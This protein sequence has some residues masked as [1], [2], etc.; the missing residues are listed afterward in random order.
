MMLMY[1]TMMLFNSG[2][3]F[4]WKSIIIL[5]ASLSSILY[6][7]L[8]SKHFPLTFNIKWNL[9]QYDEFEAD[10]WEIFQDWITLEAS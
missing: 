5:M 1:V 10:Y 3:K 7:L 8:D 2:T 9:I 4:N 6:M